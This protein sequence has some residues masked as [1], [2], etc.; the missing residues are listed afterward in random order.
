MTPP[1]DFERPALIFDFGNV[2]ATFD[3]A[4]ACARLG[5]SSGRSGAALLDQACAAGL[6]DLLTRY[7]SGMLDDAAFA[8]GFGRLIECDGLALET[9]APA[10]ADIFTL[11]EPVARLI[12]HLDAV[13]YRLVLGSNTNPIHARQFRRQ[14]AATLERFDRLVLSYEVGAVKPSARF[15]E[16]CVA[17]AGVPPGR[18]V[19]IDDRPENVAGAST[20]G[21]RALRFV[22][23]AGLV[24][25]LMR[26][27]IELPDGAWGA[28][29][30]SW[31]KSWRRI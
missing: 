24:R 9:F 30:A 27:G 3:Y 8:A 15:Y 13:G 4:R 16:A 20:A 6:G 7:E 29:C 28:G 19:F 26:L 18:C 11:N 31:E 12:E 1:A 5:A 17:A 23:V 22:D 21:L 2:V 10:W 14:F 25:D